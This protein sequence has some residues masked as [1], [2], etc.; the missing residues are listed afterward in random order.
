ME[1]SKLEQPSERAKYLLSERIKYLQTEIAVLDTFA[2]TEMFQ[3][4][5][6]IQ[7][8]L[9]REDARLNTEERDDLQQLRDKAKQRII[10][11]LKLT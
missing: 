4:I 6:E 9:L 3:Y 5:R 10:A 8:I 11:T 2:R 7:R 1:I